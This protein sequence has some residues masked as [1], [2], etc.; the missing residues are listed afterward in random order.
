MQKLLTKA[1]DYR[2]AELYDEYVAKAWSGSQPI[3]FCQPLL[4][5]V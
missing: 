5:V 4:P 2:V 1:V 3:A